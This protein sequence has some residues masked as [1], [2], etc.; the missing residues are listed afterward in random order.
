MGN[1][2]SCRVA[3]KTQTRVSDPDVAAYLGRVRA[4]GGVV[5]PSHAKAVDRFTRRP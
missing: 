3:A 2:A 5:L 4:N 1:V